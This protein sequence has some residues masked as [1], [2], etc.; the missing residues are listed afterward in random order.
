MGLTS[1]RVTLPTQYYKRYFEIV[2]FA[3]KPTAATVV[4]TCSTFPEGRY[5]NYQCVYSAEG[6]VRAADPT[7]LPPLPTRPG[8]EPP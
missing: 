5:S 1:R 3:L 4:V 8:V 7:R 2:D 6:D